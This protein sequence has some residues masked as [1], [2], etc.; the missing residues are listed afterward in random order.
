MNG[1]LADYRSDTYDE[2]VDADGAPRAHTKSLYEALELLSAG[3][4]EERGAARARSFLQQ[5]ITFSSSGEE[6]VFPLD[7]VPRL[8][9]E[10]EWDHIE[11]G[12]VQRVRALE[13]FLDDIYG[14]RSVLRDGVVAALAGVHEQQLLPRRRRHP[15]GVRRPH[16]PGRHRPRPRRGRRDARPRGQPPRAVGHLLRD[17]EPRGVD[18]RLP[19]AVPRAAGAAGGRLRR[20][21][22]RLAARRRAGRCERPDGGAAQPR[23]STTRRTSSTPSSPARWASSWSR[24]GT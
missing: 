16:P 7:L 3:D 2:M 1:L 5:G 20:H 24:G 8:I 22:A 15:P 21:A 19:R 23:A 18:P 11:A 12:V 17:R 4:L 10:D 6:W 13:A 14:N 9:A